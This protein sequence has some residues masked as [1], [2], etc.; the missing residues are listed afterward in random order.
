V[1][2]GWAAVTDSLGWAP[3][4]LFAAMFFWT[5]PHFWALA[6]RYAD[7]YRAADVPMLPAVAPLGEAARQMIVYTVALVAS[8]LLL[9]PVAELGWIYTG[10]A[11]ALGAGFL[12]GTIALAARP[13][14]SASMKVFAYSITY[15]TLLFGAMMLDVLV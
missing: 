7:D 8:T 9:T 4:V 5:P 1:L 11:L 15:V 12:G 2:V 6:I 10:A 13:N 14:P 3:V